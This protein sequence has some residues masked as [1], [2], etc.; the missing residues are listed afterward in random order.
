MPAVASCDSQRF[1][2]SASPAVTQHGPN[3]VPALASAIPPYPDGSRRWEKD[4]VMDP[5][6]KGSI[7]PCFS[8]W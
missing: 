8:S 3:L 7:V 2:P 6:P 1:L 4:A 5:E